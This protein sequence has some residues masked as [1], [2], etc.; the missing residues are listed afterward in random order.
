MEASAGLVAGSH[1]R[2]EL[3]VIRR[4]GESGVCSF[5]PLISDLSLSSTIFLKLKFGADLRNVVR[6]SG[7]GTKYQFQF[8]KPSSQIQGE[9]LSF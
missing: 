3:V 4:E 1:N 7:I 8:D 9:I 2:N 5:L 6:D